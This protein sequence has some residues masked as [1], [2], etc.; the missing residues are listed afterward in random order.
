M[1]YGTLILNI[2]KIR[3]EKGIS[4]NNIC[5]DLDIPRHTLNKYCKN[6]FQYIDAQFICK[7]CQYFACSP[8]ELITYIPATQE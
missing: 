3:L 8:A 7:L 6:E 2:D 4:K 5:K 1:N